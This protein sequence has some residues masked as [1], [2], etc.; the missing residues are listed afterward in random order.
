MIILVM[1]WRITL[2]KSGS[3]VL[4]H[5]IS[6]T[7][8]QGMCHFFNFNSGNN[9]WSPLKCPELHLA[10]DPCMCCAAADS[11]SADFCFQDRHKAFQLFKVGFRLSLQV[12]SDFW[13]QNC[14][15]WQWPLWHLLYFAIF[16][17]EIYFYS[18]EVLIIDKNITNIF[19]SWT[20]WEP[21]IMSFF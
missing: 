2:G 10:S 8:A 13:C 1:L 9:S 19:L 5:M 14:F 15:S 18:P 17:W 20:V 3:L 11:R 7:S 16:R 21:K 6:F 12:P 4:T